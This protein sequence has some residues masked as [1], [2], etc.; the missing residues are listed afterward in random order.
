MRKGSERKWRH[1]AKNKLRTGKARPSKKPIPKAHRTAQS[2]NCGLDLPVAQ[3]SFE[4]APE[5]V[6]PDVVL[7]SDETEADAQNPRYDGVAVA[8]DRELR[9]ESHGELVHGR[10]KGREAADDRR[11][12]DIRSDRN[13]DNGV[14]GDGYFGG[15][16]AEKEQER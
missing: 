3:G 6:N 2:G 16:A 7:E 10:V 5:R 8:A 14:R 4:P 11:E 13:L 12:I 1:L 9:I 15:T